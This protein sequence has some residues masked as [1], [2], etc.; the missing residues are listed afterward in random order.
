MEK[1]KAF[2]PNDIKWEPH[3]QL[4]DVQV[5][6]F[7]S[8]REDN[9]DLT[10]MLVQLPKGSQVERHIHENSDD[11]VYVLKGKATLWIDGVGD[12][13]MVPGAFFRIPTGVLHQPRDIEEELVLFDVFYPY[14][15]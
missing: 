10:I 15:A 3:P 2:Q 7:L 12:L 6:Y 13:P 14:L 11:I 8:N 9:T 5:A 1:A 4:K